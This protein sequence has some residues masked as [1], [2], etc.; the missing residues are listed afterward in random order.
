MALLNCEECGRE[1]SSRATACPH[2]GCPMSPD[3]TE[4][5]AGASD[6]I[7]SAW[8]E[9]P[10][11]EPLATASATKVPARTSPLTRFFLLALGILVLIALIRSCGADVPS[12]DSASGPQTAAQSAASVSAELP[13]GPTEAEKARWVS[14]STDSEANASNRLHAARSLVT[15]FGESPEGV[16]AQGM[17]EELEAAVA[18]ESMGRQWRYTSTEEGM[19]GKQV[20]H[21]AVQSTNTISLDFPYRGPQHATL[22]F[23]RH[24]RWGNDVILSIERGQI[25]CHSYGDCRVQVRFDDG[26]VLRF[27]GNPPADNSSESVFIPAFTTFMNS[28]PKAKAVKIEVQIYQGGAPVFEFDVSGFKPEKFK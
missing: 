23:R 7:P 3:V 28:L 26:K 15:H 12:Q 6:P 11:A 20:R 10:A 13:K 2:C 1:V 25:L 22:L 24:P 8:T 27:K 9:R 18:Y 4:S 21:A 16:H 14:Q 5:A 17:I 19:S